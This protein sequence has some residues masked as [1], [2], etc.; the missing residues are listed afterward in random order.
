MHEGGNARSGKF[1]L[2]RV[3]EVDG[4]WHYTFRGTGEMFSVMRAQ[5]SEVGQTQVRFSRIK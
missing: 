2:V 4:R 1:G 3:A 5:M